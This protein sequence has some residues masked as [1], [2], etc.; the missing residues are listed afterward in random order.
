LIDADLVG[1]TEYD[2]Y[3]NASGNDILVGTGVRLFDSTKITYQSLNKLNI[4]CM[5]LGNSV[6]F[7][8]EVPNNS[9]T[10]N[11]ESIVLRSTDSKIVHI[12][13][14]DFSGRDDVRLNICDENLNILASDVNFISVPIV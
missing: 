12:V 8:K 3:S 6:L 10:S 5:S 4:Y 1:P 13:I 14:T 9:S 11:L 7:Q 2:K